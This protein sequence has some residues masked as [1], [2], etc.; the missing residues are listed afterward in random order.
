ME[1]F[2][3]PPCVMQMIFLFRLQKS[4]TSSNSRPENT[5][6]KHEPWWLPAICN[7][8][9]EL[10]QAARLLIAG[11]YARE[12]WPCCQGRSTFLPSVLVLLLQPTLLSS[13]NP[14]SDSCKFN[15]L[16]HNLCQTITKP[17]ILKKYLI[18][19]VALFSHPRWK[20][21]IFPCTPEEVF[22]ILQ[23]IFPSVETWLISFVC[24]CTENIPPVCQLYG[25]W[26]MHT[27]ILSN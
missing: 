9:C 20:Y 13:S 14:S 3:L 10:S 8:M 24:K 23:I 5:G 6:T 26:Y 2:W 18:W 4:V 21:L 1:C 11:G 7:D 27:Y 19:T 22:F 25:H 17:F 15:T 12:A 16:V